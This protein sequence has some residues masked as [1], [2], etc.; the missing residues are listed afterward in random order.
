[1]PLFCSAKLVWLILIISCGNWD[2]PVYGVHVGILLFWVF[3]LI[4][5]GI[6]AFIDSSSSQKKKNVTHEK[7]LECTW[8]KLVGCECVDVCV[9]RIIKCFCNSIVGGVPVGTCAG[10]AWTTVLIIRSW[11]TIFATVFA[12]GFCFVLSDRALWLLEAFNRKSRVQ[13]KCSAIIKILILSSRHSHLSR[14]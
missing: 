9:E 4:S 5:T 7:R 14:K 12:A 2:V 11:K 13:I 3:F 6:V 10:V 8:T 1:M